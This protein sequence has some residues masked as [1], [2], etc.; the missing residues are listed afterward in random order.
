VNGPAA[1][2]QGMSPRELESERQRTLRLAKRRGRSKWMPVTVVILGIVGAAMAAG[3]FLAESG[4]EEL[5]IT[6]IPNEPAD[7]SKPV[8]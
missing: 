8:A 3:Y 7:P 6:N 2:F 1:Y 4:T 5:A